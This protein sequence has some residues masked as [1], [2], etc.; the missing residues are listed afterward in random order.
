VL[1]ELAEYTQDP[2][3]KE[4]LLKMASSTPEGKE[5]YMD[6]IVHDHRH[7]LAVLE[8]MPSIQPPLDHLCELLHRLHPRYY[9]ISSSYKVTLT[10][11][12]F[13]IHRNTR[14]Y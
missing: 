4:K 9:S 8:D 12:L 13:A 10:L 3:E 6:W 2:A 7:I 11:Y 1:K 14:I 5:M